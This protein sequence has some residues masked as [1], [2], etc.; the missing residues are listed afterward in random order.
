MRLNSI[1]WSASAVLIIFKTLHMINYFKKLLTGYQTASKKVHGIDLRYT[2]SD[3]PI[4][5]DPIGM[6]KE[7]KIRV[8]HEE[9]QRLMLIS[10]ISE[11]LFDFEFPGDDEKPS[12]ICECPLK[13]MNLKVSRFSLKEGLYPISFYR[14]ELNDEILGTFRRKYDYGSQIQNIGLKLA[15]VTGKAIDLDL[16][17][18]LW[19]NN[20]G[21]QLFVEKFGHTQ[22]WFF[23][24]S[25]LDSLI[26]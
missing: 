14:F 9:V 18:W 1:Q 26:N 2:Y 17:K 22:I 23:K 21:E 4:F 3:K 25:N 5:F 11:A 13:G 15:S 7:F 12:V 8:A 10:P 24:N 16:G 20:Q 19:Q 6:L